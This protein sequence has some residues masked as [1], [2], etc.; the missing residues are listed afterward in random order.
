MNNIHA[1]ISAERMTIANT[2]QVVEFAENSNLDVIGVGNIFGMMQLFV[3]GNATDISK[4]V[5][6]VHG[7]NGGNYCEA[8]LIGEEEI[9][10]R[11]YG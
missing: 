1:V 6:F 2:N 3:Q 4:I 7:I 11:L 10:D 5:P 9:E 8:E